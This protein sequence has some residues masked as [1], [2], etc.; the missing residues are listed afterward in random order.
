VLGRGAGGLNHHGDEAVALLSPA[1]QALEA[2]E[3]LI[4][5]L[6]GGHDADRQ[7]SHLLGS[8]LQGTGS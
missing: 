8:S 2:V 5:A 1:L 7:R 6:F 4:Q 3:D